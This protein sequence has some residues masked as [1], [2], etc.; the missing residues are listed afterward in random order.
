MDK[1][2]IKLP[3]VSLENFRIVHKKSGL[4]FNGYDEFYN[5]S[6]G[7]NTL[8]TTNFK[9]IFALNKDD[10]KILEK[11]FEGNI[12]MKN[13]NEYVRNIIVH[14]GSEIHIILA[15]YYIEYEYLPIQDFTVE[16]I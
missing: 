11:V 13:N 15:E 14:A 4:F 16:R 5:S 9:G 2:G 10:S 3:E 1:M 8:S 12:V 7:K 6:K